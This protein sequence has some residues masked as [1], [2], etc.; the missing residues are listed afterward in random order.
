MARYHF[1]EWNT[2]DDDARIREARYWTKAKICINNNVEWDND[3]A[4]ISAL[5]HEFGHLY[6]LDDR[7]LHKPP[8]PSP[9]PTTYCNDEEKTIMDTYKTNGGTHCDDIVAPERLDIERVHLAYRDGVLSNMSAVRTPN[10]EG[11]DT[12]QFTWNDEAW[13][14]IGHEVR[15]YFIGQPGEA[16]VQFARTGNQE[17]VWSDAGVGRHHDMISISRPPSMFMVEASPYEHLKI[18]PYR[19]IRL[20]E[21]TQYYAC[22]RP[23]FAQFP[24]VDEDDWTC[25]TPISISNAAHNASI[26]PTPTPQAVPS[27]LAVEHTTSGLRLT[28]IPPNAPK[29][30]WQRVVRRTHPQQ[31]FTAISNNLPITANS[32]TD[33]TAQPNTKYIYRIQAFKKNGKGIKISNRF[34]VTIPNRGGG[35]APLPRTLSVGETATVRAI[36]ISP[37]WLDYKFRVGGP[38]AVGGAD[39]PPPVGGSSATDP[40]EI[41]ESRVEF[42]IEACAEGVITVSLLASADNHELARA[43]VTVNAAPRSATHTPTAAPTPTATPFT[44]TATP[45]ATASPTP[46]PFATPTPT[47]NPAYI[48]SISVL[49]TE[50]AIGESVEVSGLFSPPDLSVALELVSGDSLRTSPCAGVSGAFVMARTPGRATVNYYGC[51]AGVSEIALKASGQVLDSVSITVFNPTPTPTPQP[52]GE[53]VASPSSLPQGNWSRISA[54]NLIPSGLSVRIEADGTRLALNPRDCAA[55]GNSDEPPPG[56][57][58]GQADRSLGNVYGCETGSGWVRMVATSDNAELAKIYI[59]V[60]ERPTPTPFVRVRT[61]PTPT[62][63]TMPTATPTRTSTATPTLGRSGELVASLRTLPK[64]NWSRISA[65]NLTPSGLSVRIEADGSRLALNPRNC[66]SAGN[67]EEPPPGGAVGQTS[68]FLGNVYGCETGIGWVKMVATSDNAELAKIYITVRPRPTATPRSRPRPTVAPRPTAA[69]QPTAI[70]TVAP[71]PTPQPTAAP[72]PRPTATPRT[73]TTCERYP[74]LN[75]CRNPAWGLGGQAE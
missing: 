53:L 36:N 32:Y 26:T 22:G 70:P 64:G 25:S 72:R 54:R 18:E 34:V 30:F 8:T 65:R 74:W 13:G 47:P 43:T 63:T 19:R 58:V 68:R 28:W 24:S 55:A 35:L 61:T 6:G 59:T 71:Q 49:R 62:P 31:N 38:L 3:D 40:V 17:R 33:A 29:L 50:I 15:F 12:I 14:E 73:L 51:S 41:G 21:S 46:T 5:V 42:E 60:R 4:K 75:V 7:Y 23:V 37:K 52:S 11:E 44:P 27:G 67:S 69:P 2:N 56:G 10:S 57:A 1:N 16:P 9:T 45:T 39:C 66:P 48:G 20:P